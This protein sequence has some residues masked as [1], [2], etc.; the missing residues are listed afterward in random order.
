MSPYRILRVVPDL[1]IGG[2]QRMMQR[3]IQAFLDRGHHCAVCCIGRRPGQ[4]TRN[5]K[6]AGI[7]V[8]SIPFRM[9]L[10]PL[11]LWRLRHL[12]RR[13]R[14]DVVHAHMYAASMAVN[15][16]LWGVQG[17]GV[18]NN[19]HSIRPVHGESQAR[20]LLK[21][22]HLPHGLIAVSEAVKLALVELGLP[23]D[24]LHVIH[25]GVD[26]PDEPVPLPERQS[27]AP[28]ELLWAGR[29]VKQ[30]R[31]DFY[32]ELMH[33][34][35]RAGL[36]VRLTLAGDGPT[37]QALQR[38]IAKEGLE[39]MIHLP[40]WIREIREHLRTI[41]LYVCSSVREGF[42]NTL[43][44]AATVGRGMILSDIAPHREFLGHSNAGLIPGDDPECWRRALEELGGD[45]ERLASMGREAFERV[46]QYSLPN[47]GRLLLEQYEQAVRLASKNR[48]EPT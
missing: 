21:T 3:S 42:S 13:G 23:D 4:M 8:H 6:R 9:R 5:F 36:N 33:A 40:G 47:H 29:F 10:D 2:V 20:R 14:Y 16:A 32:I 27:E 22:A 12:V 39:H 34:C 31:L 18:L 7:T 45:R 37:R 15:Y 28:L 24:I 44:E 38:R 17:V 11:G 30:K 1:Q 19:Y 48:G 35:R 41:D 46:K 26:L 25:N 43:L